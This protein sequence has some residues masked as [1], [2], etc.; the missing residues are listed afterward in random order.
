M[1]P[2]RRPIAYAVSVV[3]ER[4][5]AERRLEEEVVAESG[6]EAG[7]RAR[8]GTRSVRDRDGEDEAEIRDDAED[9]QVR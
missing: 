8:F 3:R 7:E 9:A 5:E 2:A 4:R 6:R 1:P